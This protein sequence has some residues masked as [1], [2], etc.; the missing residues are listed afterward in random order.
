VQFVSEVAKLIP[1]ASIIIDGSFVMACVDEPDDIDLLLVLPADWN[2]SAELNPF[3][4][5]LVA[6]HMVKRRFGLDAFTA[7]EGSQREAEFIEFFGKVNVKWHRPPLNLPVS[8]S[9]GIVRIVS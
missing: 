3:V 4:Y 7:V 6:K 1:D 2:M 9:K 5:N 8:L